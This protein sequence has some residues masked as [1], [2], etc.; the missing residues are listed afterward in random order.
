MA[1][2]G[3]GK[4]PKQPMQSRGP[5]RPRRRGGPGL[6]GLDAYAAD[7]ARL[8]ADPCNARLTK[9]ISMGS[10]GSIVI[11]L[12]AD[13]I[14][15]TA[16]ADT[17]GAVFWVPGGNLAYA[18]ASTTDTSTL[19]LGNS[20]PGVAAGSGFLGANASAF[21]CIAA[22][23]QLMFPGT[24]LQ[25]SGVV[26]MGIMPTSTVG[27]LLPVSIGG[28]G[29][30]TTLGNLRSLCQYTK[31]VPDEMTEMTW[32]PGQADGNMNNADAIAGNDLQA[33]AGKNGILISASGL[34]AGVGIRIRTVAVYEY[35]PFVGNGVVA[36]VETTRSVNTVND[37]LRTLDNAIPQWFIDGF[38]KV[39]ITALRAGAGYMTGGASEAMI[40]QLSLGG[41]RSV[42]RVGY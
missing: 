6:A 20:V 25:R 37:V 7:Y 24:E 42:K 29:G 40:S 15:F 8:V 12:E 41:S 22:C 14:L 3:K 27:G 21:R 1:K 36:T 13:A 32:R 33:Q 5:T 26:A 9:G 34:P 31:R 4:K 16:G 23:A 17:G 35:E 19:T 10:E 18:G 30:L 2:R 28:Q 11:R 38:K 39:G